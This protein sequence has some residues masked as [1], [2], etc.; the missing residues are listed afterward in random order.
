MVCSGVLELLSVTLSK[1]VIIIALLPL[2][3]LQ[4]IGCTFQLCVPAL[5][6]GI[7]PNCTFRNR[8]SQCLGFNVRFVA[9]E[10]AHDQCG[11]ITFKPQLAVRVRAT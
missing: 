11:S 1:D 9:E 8:I 5:D 10:L 4:R 3:L 6:P 2:E 7:Y